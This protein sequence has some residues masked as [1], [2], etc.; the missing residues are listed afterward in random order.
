MTAIDAGLDP[1]L[2]GLGPPPP[3]R[4]TDIQAKIISTMAFDNADWV[5]KM[6]QL[7]N[8]G[9]TPEQVQGAIAALA[10]ISGEVCTTTV[11]DCVPYG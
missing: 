6:W 4:L 2:V 11:E 5:G 1:K 9:Y 7:S 8:H 3:P 10:R